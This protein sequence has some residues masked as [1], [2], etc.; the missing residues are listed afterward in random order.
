MPGED[1]V[2]D[3]Q[4]TYESIDGFG[5][6]KG[7]TVSAIG[8]QYTEKKKAE[9]FLEKYKEL[10]F[11]LVKGIVSKFDFIKDNLRLWLTLN[12]E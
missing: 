8:T 7:M 6:D 11:C 2:G 3:V 1:T 12:I 9:I 5:A 10:K 4:V